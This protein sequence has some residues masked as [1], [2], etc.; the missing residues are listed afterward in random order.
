MRR[1]L[2]LFAPLL[3]WAV[4][5]MGVYGIASVAAVVSRP[6]APASR[7]AVGALTLLCAGACALFLALVL[8]RRPP[9]DEAD[10]FIN[11]I[12]GLGAGVSLVAILWQGL[13][14]LV[15]H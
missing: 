10:R 15:G 12:A 1:W 3:I 6:D 13:P 11:S 2:F 4:H 7:L 9:Q 8:R 5:F 14:A